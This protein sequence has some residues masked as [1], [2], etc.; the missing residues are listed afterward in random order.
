MLI[1]VDSLPVFGRIDS[2]LPSG[3]SY[4]RALTKPLVRSFRLFGRAIGAS[5]WH[6]LSDNRQY[7]FSK[8]L[9]ALFFVQCGNTRHSAVTVGKA[10]ARRDFGIWPFIC[11]LKSTE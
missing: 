9:R 11:L 8:T 1:E 4:C 2:L 5:A 7:L 3:C 10:S 6:E